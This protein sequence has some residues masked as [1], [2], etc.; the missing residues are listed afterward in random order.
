MT[1]DRTDITA[2]YSRLRCGFTLI[3]ATLST[4]I[5]ATMIVAALHT[6]G[7]AAVGRRVLQSRVVADALA[8]RLL[9][10]II[11]IRFEEPDETLAFGP[12]TSE[13]GGTRDAFDDLD[14]YHSWS[15]SAPQAKDGTEISALTGWS[16]SVVVENVDVET[17]A[18]AGATRTGLKRITVTV[19]DP[20]D[21]QTTATALRSDSSCYDQADPAS[22]TTYVAWAGITLQIGFDQATRIYSGVRTLNLVPLPE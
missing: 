5:V 4:L 21:K 12:E 1:R 8:A 10:E 14:D 19:Q 3:E 18:P 17:L 11:Q 13:T 22:Q 6:F 15:A 20:D 7:S 2:R 16:R 9:S